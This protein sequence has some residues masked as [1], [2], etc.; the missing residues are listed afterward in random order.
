MVS[1]LH[2]FKVEASKTIK[3]VLKW[4]KTS[5]GSTIPSCFGKRQKLL[6]VEL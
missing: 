4:A 2:I 1:Q 6:Q 3:K 5:I